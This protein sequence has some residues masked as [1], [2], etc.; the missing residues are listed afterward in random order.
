M[1]NEFKVDNEMT[2]NNLLNIVR[3]KIQKENNEMSIESKTIIYEKKKIEK[4]MDESIKNYEAIMEKIK[5]YE[6]KDEVIKNNEFGR[7]N[8]EI[9][10][11]EVK[12]FKND[13]DF[14]DKVFSLHIIYYIIKFIF[15]DIILKSM[16]TYINETKYLKINNSRKIYE[17]KGKTNIIENNIVFRNYLSKTY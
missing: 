14:L 16:N 3:I 1:Q 11:N 17:Q 15:N 4:A 10:E 13:C 6:S 5:K 7:N 8:E 2:S 9:K 12:K